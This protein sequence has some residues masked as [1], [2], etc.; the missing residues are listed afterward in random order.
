MPDE[1]DEERCAAV[2]VPCQVDEAGAVSLVLILRSGGFN[3]HAG[4]AAFPGGRHDP[5][6]DASLLATALREAEEEIGLAR[7]D[8]SVLGALPERRTL[9]SRYSVT[10]FV[11]RIPA[12]YPF[13]ADPREVDAIFSAPLARFALEA[14]RRSLEWAHEGTKYVVPAVP[15]GPHVVWG[16]TLQIIEDLLRSEIRMI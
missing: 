7:C 16:L 6:R 13:H 5:D 2:L 9:S 12:R 3:H 10:P 14:P 8:V 1:G 11:G 4:Q 15:I